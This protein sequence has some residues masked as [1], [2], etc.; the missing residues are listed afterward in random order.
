MFPQSRRNNSQMLYMICLILRVN[1]DVIDKHDHELI[2]IG[3]EYQIHQIHKVGRCI[4]QSK[5][6]NQILVQA[7][8]SG[9]SCFRYILWPDLNLMIAKPQVNLREYLC[10]CQLIEQD[11]DTRQRM[12]VLNGHNIKQPIIHTHSQRLVLLLY[13]QCWTSPW[14]RTR[15]NETFVQ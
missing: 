6:H 12:L 10:F 8:P 9:E 1:Q 13:K 11:I 5:R 4:C 3:H 2:E 14:R 7:V 15:L